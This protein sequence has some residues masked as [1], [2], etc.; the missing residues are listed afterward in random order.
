MT[1]VH[2]H[3]VPRSYVSL[4]V[5]LAGVKD[6]DGRVWNQIAYEGQ[7]KGHSAGEFQFTAATFHA[8]TQ[9][10]QRRT[11]PIPLTW[12]HPDG[13]TGA[14]MG[15]AGWIHALKV[16]RDDQGR[17]ALFALM[18]FTPRAA[19]MVKAGEHRHC[20]VVVGFDG[21][22]EKTGEPIGAELYEV[23]LVLSAFIDGMTRLAASIDG[24]AQPAGQ[25]ALSKDKTTMTDKEL[26]AAAFKELGDDATAENAMKWVEIEKSKAALLSGD[27]EE[28]PAEEPEEPEEMAAG[29][30]QPAEVVQ[31]A[32]EPADPA[33]AEAMP[34]GPPE[35]DAA[36]SMALDL[37]RTLAAELGVDFPALI[38]SMSENIDAIKS[39][40]GAAPEDGTQA[41]APAAMSK[42]HESAVVE[43]SRA[44]KANAELSEQMK[45]TAGTVERLR[46]EI[47]LSRH[48]RDGKISKGAM[49]EM[50]KAADDDAYKA[51][52]EQA[53]KMLSA[54][55]DGPSVV[56][57]GRKY[58]AREPEKGGPV[59][60][61]DEAIESATASLSAKL[62]KDGKKLTRKDRSKVYSLAKA[63]HPEAFG[64]RK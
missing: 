36:D 6:T 53:Q 34:D 11:D 55:L 32:D 56:P 7:W 10:F 12:G 33:A 13:E 52:L 41:E 5:S 39:A 58:Q 25:R 46:F 59:M 17:D 30:E 42:S 61:P 23:G 22:D 45:E 62:A 16:E 31:L 64:I 50:L 44:Q 27:A 49:G 38:A 1:V 24:R 43:L 60:T 57:L 2:M 37:L 26:L 28:T 29:A 48:E 14:L 51:P 3:E 35:D 47:E 15:A 9:N 19:S 18:E 20:S 4:S 21:V 40:L 63:M 8:L 54:A